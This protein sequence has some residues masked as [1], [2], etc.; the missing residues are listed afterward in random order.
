MKLWVPALAA[1]SICLSVQA[2]AQQEAT[3]GVAD[4]Q[5]AATLPNAV[6]PEGIIHLDFAVT[7]KS[8]KPV[9]G[10]KAEDFNLLD[11]GWPTKLVSF[12]GFD[13][14]VARP[15]R[16]TE[17]ILVLDAVNLWPQQVT[18]AERE[19]G[20]FLRAHEGHLAQPIVI[21]RLSTSGLSESTEPT[22]DGNRLADEVARGT[23]PRIVWQQD[24]RRIEASLPDDYARKRNAFSLTGLG[25][26]A[27]EERR[28]PGR[29]L[30]F[31]IGPGWPVKSGG[32]YTF[33]E[34]VELST[35]LREARIVLS[36]VTAWPDPEPESSSRDFLTGL[37]SAKDGSPFD[38]ALKVLAMQSGG[39]VM[40]PAF[41]LKGLIEKCI[42]KAND[43]YSLTFDPP[44]TAVVDEYHDLKIK[45]KNP[46]LIAR[47]NYGYYDEPVFYDQ[48]APV[49]ER[50]T[51]ARL[52]QILL[53][54]HERRDEDLAQQFNGLELTERMPSARLTLWKARMPG[55]KS[56]AALVVLADKS[57]FL[58]PPAETVV[59][60]PAP[61][62][63]T[64]SQM[65]LRTV[66]YL[67][68]AFPKLPD[69]FATRTTIRYEEPKQRDEETWKSV[70]RDQ[71]LRQAE[72]TKVTM[73]IRNG[74]EETDASV[75]KGKHTPGR[76][77]SLD[78]EG[79]FG[80]I[81]AMVLFGA[82]WPH[83]HL[84][85]SRWE[86][87]SDG[88][89]AIFSYI[90]PQE[91][92]LFEVGFCC[93]ADP[94]GTI[95]FE[96]KSGYHG[97]IAIDP[98]SGAILRIVVIADLEQRLPLA[99]SG[100]VVEYGPVAIGG[101]TYIYP[102]RS[103]ALTRSRTVRILHEWNESFGV[104]GPFETMMNDAT[105]DDYHMFRSSSRI[106]AWEDPGP[107]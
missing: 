106:V 18:T 31:W 94:D 53:N 69:I 20:K 30:L 87:G 48:P 2:F 79:T 97:E 76:E 47:T 8:G 52:E 34:V 66:A 92:A 54:A 3:T 88:V 98:T 107:Q 86:Q 11:N 7:D 28:R 10:L 12:H 95:P 71:S 6:E 9:T 91:M 70:V 24:A 83:S 21:Y 43:F 62:V 102:T 32:E 60:N 61:D 40:E 45:M 101:K 56:K 80:P 14:T 81:L 59:S 27:I 36:S 78:T 16:L 37:K 26:I 46:D 74:K 41:D 22:L 35:R 50:V 75:K 72:T 64:Q 49:T 1:V 89:E 33:D 67:K 15:D 58:A 99:W 82:S 104:Y 38:L 4:Q 100:V 25:S 44:R 63:A 85:W 73:V 5:P 29:K 55:S 84:A 93:M 23:E 68:Q 57:G 65:L 77:R 42:D 13:E 17:V 90:V 51:V 19:L 103:V 96:R 105:F 39:R